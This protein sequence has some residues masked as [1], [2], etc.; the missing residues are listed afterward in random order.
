[1]AK[2]T[3]KKP[4]L[5]GKAAKINSVITKI[6]RIADYSA[7]TGD[8]KKQKVGD[9]VHAANSAEAKTAYFGRKFSGFTGKI[10]TNGSAEKNDAAVAILKDF[11][12]KKD[13]EAQRKVAQSTLESLW[14][15]Y[16]GTGGGGS[17]GLSN[18][19]VSMDDLNF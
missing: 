13:V 10:R 4:A 6:K 11:A 1:M 15:N 14:A 12:S 7:F 16:A 18:T 8:V 3:V 17:R 19:A 5:T 2:E 9:K